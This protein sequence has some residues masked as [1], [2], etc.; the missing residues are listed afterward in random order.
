MSNVWMSGVSMSAQEHRRPNETNRVFIPTTS[1]ATD[2]HTVWITRALGKSDLHLHRD[3]RGSWRCVI[4]DALFSLHRTFACVDATHTT[5]AD[6][7]VKLCLCAWSS[8]KW[9]HTHAQPQR[10]RRKPLFEMNFH[11]KMGKMRLL[12]VLATTSTTT[13]AAVPTS[14][15]KK[16]KCAH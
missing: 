10:R 6:V 3:P 13:A 2:A 15:Q 4:P 7:W 1:Q 9:I 8:R 16:T 14:T 11:S 12:P 5:I